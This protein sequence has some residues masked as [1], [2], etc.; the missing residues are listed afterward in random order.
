LAKLGGFNGAKSD[1]LP[2]LKVIWLGLNKLYTL[3]AYRD[4]LT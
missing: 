3:A 4:F 1:G 2:G